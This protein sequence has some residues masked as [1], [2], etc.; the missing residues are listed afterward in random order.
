MALRLVSSLSVKNE[1]ARDTDLSKKT[2]KPPHLVAHRLCK[3]ADIMETARAK[4][5]KAVIWSKQ[6]LEP[7]GKTDGGEEE[8]RGDALVVLH[9]LH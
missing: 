3:C 2:G 4:S 7:P 6:N 8:T 1:I 9:V 5:E